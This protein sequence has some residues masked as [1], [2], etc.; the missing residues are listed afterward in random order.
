MGI[1]KKLK[2]LNNNT[3]LSEKELAILKLWRTTT[4]AKFE[5]IDNKLDL[6]Q[7][8]FVEINDKLQ[9][10]KDKLIDHEQRIRALE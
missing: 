7:A 4:I 5:Q 6:A 8:E 1:Q 10:A 2:D 3:T 9:Q